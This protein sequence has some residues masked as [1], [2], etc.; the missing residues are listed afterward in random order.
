MLDIQ[1]P[2]PGLS[3]GAV[4]R[5]V[6]LGNVHDAGIRNDL[7]AAFKRHGIL[8]FKELPVDADLHALHVELS[9]V[10][11]ELALHPM[12][13]QMEVEGHPELIKLKYEPDTETIFDVDGEKLGGYIPWH[14]DGVFVDKIN[15]GGILR[16]VTIP[17][18]RGE[19]GFIDGIDAYDR[20]PQRLKDRI[21]GLNGVYQLSFQ[22]PFVP[23]QKVHV[24]VEGDLF[25]N[26]RLR[27][28]AGHFPPVV[29]PL[30][31]RQEETGRKILNFSP[32]FAKSVQGLGDEEAHEL[33]LELG[34]HITNESRAYV[35]PWTSMG[36]MVLWD[37][38]RLLHKSFGVP[39]DSHRAVIRTTIA[40]DYGFGYYLDGDRQAA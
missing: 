31:Y 25:R 22:Y 26:S 20:L 39:I 21:E 23:R 40:G 37:N 35:H 5:G 28:E 32:L 3:Y 2:L 33:L 30:V 34:Y 12:R 27:L 14:F 19:T 18:S 1:A 38:W 36:E 8:V 6:T 15:R 29:H 9:R 11:G 13:A 4:V 7:A 10:F 16:I 17:E 24:H